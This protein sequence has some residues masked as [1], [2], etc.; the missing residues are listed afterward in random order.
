MD[1]APVRVFAAERR[2]GDLSAG[3]AAL[4]VAERGENE[5]AGKRNSGAH[6]G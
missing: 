5:A 6:C 3:H 1:S 2:A 4:N